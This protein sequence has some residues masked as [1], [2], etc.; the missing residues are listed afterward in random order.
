M[1]MKTYRIRFNMA[2]YRATPILCER[3]GFGA[4]NEGIKVLADTP[5]QAVEHY[6]RERLPGE[7]LNAFYLKVEEVK[8]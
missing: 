7:Q 3:A 2:N 1:T 6:N 8:A 5:E 4:R